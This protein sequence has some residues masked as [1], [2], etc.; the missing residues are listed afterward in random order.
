MDS[1]VLVCELDG[2]TDDRI[3]QERAAELFPPPPAERAEKGARRKSRQHILAWLLLG[4]AVKEQFGYTLPQ[5]CVCRGEHGKPFGS[6][7]PEIQFNISHCETACA[8][9]VGRVPA[10]VDVERKFRC[11]DGLLKKACHPEEYE[12][13]AQMEE[14]DR[15]RQFRFLWSLKESFVKMDGRGL[16]YG[17]DRLSFARLLPIS[18]G[19]GKAFQGTS[20]P[21]SLLLC[22]RESYTLAAYE[23][24]S[25]DAAWNPDAA[26]RW[27]PAEIR[28]IKESDL[29]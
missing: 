28:I 25:A 12:L 16:G 4:H 1:L 20:D 27:A 7:H 24:E 17:L 23:S 5:L 21:A 22:D 15:E 18:L 26:V 11:R 8:C 9:V 3:L 13:L 10:G 2:T 14:A 19:P 6:A 29:L